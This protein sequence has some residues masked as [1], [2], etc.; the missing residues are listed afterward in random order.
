[1]TMIVVSPCVTGV[2]KYNM[3]VYYKSQEVAMKLGDLIGSNKM[4]PNFYNCILP[5]PVVISV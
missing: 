5:D 3:F 2:K 4:L 1:M